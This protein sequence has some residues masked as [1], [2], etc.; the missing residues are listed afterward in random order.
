MKVSTTWILPC[1]LLLAACQLVT[2]QDEP[3][4]LWI[5]V[6]ITQVAELERQNGT[7]GGSSAEGIGAWFQNPSS[8][9]SAHYVVDQQ[10]VVAQCVRERDTAWANGRIEA[11]A[12]PWWT[13]NPNAVTI[14]I[15]HVKSATDNSNELTAAQR[16][17]SWRLIRNIIA[18][19]PGIKAAWA[20]S[21]GGITGHY[22]ISPISRERCPGPFPWAEM[23]E[24]I[25]GSG[26]APCVGTVTAD[27]LRVRAQPNTQ[28]AIVATYYNGDSVTISERVTGESVSGNTG[29]FRVAQGYVSAYYITL[30]DPKPEWCF[31]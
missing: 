27:A 17:A 20:D 13:T 28:A 10:G 19:N 26:D 11:G 31:K 5:P 4:A 6:R 22:S 14:S 1:A 24:A 12:D 2:S 8:Q 9:V 30:R 7:A 29:W 21:T 16:Q 25:G 18:R 23:F 15:E 3:G